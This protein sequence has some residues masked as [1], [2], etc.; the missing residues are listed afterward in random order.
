MDQDL[1]RFYLDAFPQYLEADVL[2]VLN[3]LQSYGTKVH[4][5]HAYQIFVKQE[6]IHLPVRTYFKLPNNQQ[7]SNFP[8]TQQK[9]LCCI[10]TRHHDGFIRQTM[11]ERLLNSPLDD[12]VIPYVFQ[13]LGEYVQEILHSIEPFI[14]IENQAHFAEFILENPKYFRTTESRIVS[15]WNEYYRGK[16]PNFNDYIGAKI[17][18]KLRSLVRN[19]D[20]SSSQK[21]SI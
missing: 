2:V 3:Y 13:L 18:E 19:Y 1:Q 5:K 7:F 11:L 9:I 4:S 14:N 16:Y 10:Y 21:Q 6:V 15:Y 12:F 17:L 8:I 20:H